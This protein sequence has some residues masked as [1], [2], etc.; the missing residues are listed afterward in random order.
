MPKKICTGSFLPLNSMFVNKGVAERWSIVVKQAKGRRD[1]M[2][3]KIVPYFF[4]AK[5]MLKKFARKI[6]FAIL[7]CFG[8]K[9]TFWVN[10]SSCPNFEQKKMPRNYILY[11]EINSN[12]IFFT[13]KSLEKAKKIHFMILL[14]IVQSYS[15][16][17]T[18]AKTKTLSSDFK[19]ALKYKKKHNFTVYIYKMLNKKYSISKL[20]Q[21][22]SKMLQNYESYG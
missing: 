2:R 18:I 1:I 3:K 9:Y 4:C 10:C 19:V 21:S 13:R 11:W 12:L 5:T 22:Y 7:K 15:K 17:S 8:V 6:V 14:Q 16:Y 20:V